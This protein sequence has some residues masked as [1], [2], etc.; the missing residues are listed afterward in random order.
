MRSVYRVLAYVIAALV[1][2]QAAAIAF[3]VFGLTKWVDDGGTLNKAAMESDDTEFTGVVGF[4]IHGMNGMMLIPLV[5]L[6]LLI[7]S[8]FAKVPGG[9]K[10]AGFVLLSV[11]VQVL[12]GMFAHDAPALGALHGLNALILF[13]LAVTAGMRV[14]RAEVRTTDGSVR[15]PAV[16]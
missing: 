10:W 5:A 11:V 15:D 14:R 4:M 6:V 9:V 1:V 12:L 8:F 16:A 2:V 3:A 13:G 7:V